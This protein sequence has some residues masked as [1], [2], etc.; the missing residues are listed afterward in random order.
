MTCIVYSIFRNPNK[1]SLQLPDG[2]QE[3]QVQVG[4]R[5]GLWVASS[6]IDTQ[7]L[8]GTV[9]EAMRFFSVNEAVFDRQDIP[10][11]IPL[12]Y[13]TV[14]MDPT[15]VIECVHRQ[16]SR[17]DQVLD[18]LNGC[19]EMGLRILSSDQAGMKQKY[20]PEGTSLA[21]SGTAYLRSRQEKSRMHMME[22]EKLQEVMDHITA[23]FSGYC[24]SC[25]QETGQGHGRHLPGIYFL[26]P[27]EGRAAF[28]AQFQS[29][30]C[31]EKW[32][33]LMTGLWPPY[34]FVSQEVFDHANGI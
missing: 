15:S 24:R 19:G 3:S 17:L 6:L 2:V 33:V 31:P 7:K 27:K 34:N 18:F 10:S 13:Q 9:Q 16:R 8:A 28:E 14:P 29:L 12:R 22:E 32:K 4:E 5:E 11:M 21:S 20:Q 26:V 30:V 25:L 1:I 23:H